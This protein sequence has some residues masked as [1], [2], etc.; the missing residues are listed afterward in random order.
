MKQIHKLALA[1]LAG[2]A[3]GASAIQSIHA[4]AKPPVYVINEIDVTDPAGFKTYADR[5]GDLIASFGGHFLARGGKTETISGAAP[6]QRTTIYVV[7]SMEKVQAWR[8][9]PQQKELAALRD[10]SSSFRSFAVEGLAH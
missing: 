3:F 2:T 5:Q 7:D 9:A 4:Q 8:D 10:K 6:H 1:I